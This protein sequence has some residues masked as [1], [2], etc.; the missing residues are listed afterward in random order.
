MISLVTSGQ[1]YPRYASA[2]RACRG[3]VTRQQ[4]ESGTSVGRPHV[5]VAAEQVRR[6]VVALEPGKPVVD[7]RAVGGVYL[8]AVGGEVDEVLLNECG[9]RAAARAR[10]A[11]MCL[12]S[13]AGR[14]G[15]G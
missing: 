7:L 13:S 5:L 14:S 10:F 15:S 3:L 2:G 11:P 12:A 9:A 6:V 4:K 1:R 8:V